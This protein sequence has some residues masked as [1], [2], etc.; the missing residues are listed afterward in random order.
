MTIALQTSI[1]SLESQLALLREVDAVTREQ[2]ACLEG[3]DYEGVVMHLRRRHTLLDRLAQLAAAPSAPAE[4]ETRNVNN[5]EIGR[6]VREILSFDEQARRRIEERQRT[7]QSSLDE[8][9]RGRSALAGYRGG[10]EVVPQIID[11][12]P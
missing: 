3:G 2:F 9:R 12:T 10:Q 7:V 11:L 8:V 4:D 5:E 6:L 1:D